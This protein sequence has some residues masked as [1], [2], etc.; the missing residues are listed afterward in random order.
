MKYRKV[1]ILPPYACCLCHDGKKFYRGPK[2]TVLGS[3]HG[4]ENSALHYGVEWGGKTFDMFLD[5]A[6]N[7]KY[8]EYIPQKVLFMLLY[9]ICIQII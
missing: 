1:F 2:I 3:G 8:S 6:V 7:L 9:L 4:E 5:F